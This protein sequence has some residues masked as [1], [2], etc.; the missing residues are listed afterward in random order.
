MKLSVIIPVFNEENIIEDALI[1]IGLYL[2]GQEIDDYE[3]LIIDDCSSDNSYYKVLGCIKKIG[4]ETEPN[5]KIKLY[6]NLK[7]RGKGYSILRGLYHANGDYFLTMDCDFSTDIS[8]IKKLMKYKKDYDFI[9]GSRYMSD[10][11]I[12]KK[13]TKLRIFYSRC[14]NILIRILFNLNFKDTQNGFKVYTK[15]SRHLILKYGK[16]ERY[17]FDVEH[18]VICKEHNL[19]IKEVGIEWSDNKPQKFTKHI[20]P[21]FIDLLKI[22]KYQMRGLYG[23]NT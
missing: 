7:N 2:K 18:F 5:N 9:V 16:I 6:S 14:Y 17:S 20:I 19:K 10:S 3:I 8:E 22:K 4:D 1:R 12:K 13:Q 21:M 15:K 23:K 11:I